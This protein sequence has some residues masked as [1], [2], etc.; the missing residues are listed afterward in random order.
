MCGLFGLSFTSEKPSQ[1]WW[2]DHLQQVNEVQK[3]RGPDEQNCWISP[4][5]NLG[6]AHQRLAI[7]ELSPAG[8]QPMLSRSGRSTLVFNGEIYNHQELRRKLSATSY[9]GHSDTETLVE[10][11]EVH[12]EKALNDLD[13]MFSFAWLDLSRQKVLLAVDPAGKKPLYT[14]WDGKTFAVSSEMKSFRCIPQ[15]HLTVND[16]FVKQYL[17]YGYVPYPHTIYS[18]VRKLPAGSFQWIDLKNG[19]EA[20]QIYWDLPLKPSSDK[21]SYPDAQMQLQ[22]LLT[23]AVRKRLVADVPVG[24]FLSGGLD[25]SVVSLLA[26]DILSPRALQT[27]SVSFKSQGVPGHYDESVYARYVAEK[28]HSEHHEI[29]VEVHGL[30]PSAIVTHFDEPFADS[31]AIPTYLLA[32][33]TAR[34]VKVALSGDGGDELFAGYMRFRAGLISSEYA[35]LL[36][37]LLAPM[38]FGKVP[39]RSWKGFLQRFKERLQSSTLE[40]QLSWNSY[41]NQED[42]QTYLQDCA[43]DLYLQAQEFEEKTKD[44]DVGQKILYYNFKTYLFDD[45]LPKVDRMSMAHG[46]EVRCPF[47]DKKLIEFA[48]RLPTDYKMSFFTTKRILKELFETR[49]GSDFVHRKKQGFALPIENFMEQQGVDFALTQTQQALPQ[50]VWNE[51]SLPTLKAHQH[52]HKAYMLLSL[53]K[54][55][56]SL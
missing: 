56:R 17:V 55:L 28:I 20:V 11:L 52:H 38:K 16:T 45:L 47:L 39:P 1:E 46:L 14:Y 12:Q 3:H 9:R 24:S 51:K 43:Q 29:P 40:Q 33:E 8:R 27:F 41:F 49:L 50:F 42:F 31:S 44:L 37:P 23:E 6:F 26:A 10:L 2:R 34:W 25:S 22:N 13:G 21:L 30:D 18:Q 7:L 5:R 48:F 32:R 35:W 54:N 4:E 19:P 53:E 36:K 15:I